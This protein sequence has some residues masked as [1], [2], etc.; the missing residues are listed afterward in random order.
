GTAGRSTSVPGA[1]RLPGLRRRWSPAPAHGVQ[2]PSLRGDPAACANGLKREAGEVRRA[3]ACVAPRPFRHC[4]RNGRR[5]APAHPPLSRPAPGRTGR[6]RGRSRRLQLASPE[7][8]HEARVHR[9][10]PIVMRRASRRRCRR[11]P[12]ADSAANVLPPCKRMRALRRPS[13]ACTHPRAAPARV[14]TCRAGFHLVSRAWVRAKEKHPMQSRI[15]AL[16]VAVALSASEPALAEGAAAVDLDE[17][18]VTA[19]RT[20]VALADSLFPVQV[21]DHDE[22]LRSQARSLTDLLRGRA[23]IDIGNQGGYGKL[24]NVFMRG[25]EA[26]QV[27]V[28]VDGVRVGSVTAGLTAFQD[29]PVDQIDR[30]EIVRGPRSSLYGSEAIGGVIQIFTRRDDGA[31][32]PR[33]RLGV[34]SH[35]LREA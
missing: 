14:R 10:G 20:Q 9:P 33:M 18:V 7:T 3:S 24:S 5:V 32:A 35:G 15:L 1:L 17:V 6:R 8:G 26:D 25:A 23:G 4:P 19:T 28:L 31:F 11:A 21:I 13:C 2:S 22:I 30:I 16:A 12:R 34:G 27:L 29:L